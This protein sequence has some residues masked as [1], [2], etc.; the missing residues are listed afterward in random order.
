[1]GSTITQH[2]VKNLLRGAR[3]LGLSAAGDAGIGALLT[4]FPSSLPCALF[5]DNCKNKSFPDY[6]KTR[7]V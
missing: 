1:M 6:C 7:S 5:A 3:N 4:V 2:V